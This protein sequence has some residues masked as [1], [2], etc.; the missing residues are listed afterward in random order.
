MMLRDLSH[1]GMFESSS[2]ERD[3][4]TMSPAYGINVLGYVSPSMLANL[5]VATDITVL[6]PVALMVG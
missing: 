5:I 4:H 2:S 6:V 1:M 3:V